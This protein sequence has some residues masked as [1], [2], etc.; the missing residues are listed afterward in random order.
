M[1][2]FG[3]RS[4]VGFVPRLAGLC[5]VGVLALAPG[6]LGGCAGGAD[7]EPV[8]TPASIAL[9][10]RPAVVTRT[11]VRPD[12]GGVVSPGGT[13]QARAAVRSADLDYLDALER[14]PAISN[15]DAITGMLLITT[16][17]IGRDYPARVAEAQRAGLIAGEADGPPPAPRRAANAGDVSRLVALALRAVE[18]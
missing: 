1:Q 9:R 17:R 12:G 4:G 13:G 11:A 8:I 6:L 5:V 7:A 2:T 3:R 10:E 18:P 16:G 14:R 15:D